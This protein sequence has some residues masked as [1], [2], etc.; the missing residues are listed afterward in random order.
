MVSQMKINWRA[1]LL[2]L[3]SDDCSFF[4]LS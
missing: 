2:G 4:C 3:G 1:I